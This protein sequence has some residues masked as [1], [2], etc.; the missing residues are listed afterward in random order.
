MM[1]L[2]IHYARLRRRWL[3]ITLLLTA[4]SFLL[5]FGVAQAASAHLAWDYTQAPGNPATG[6]YVEVCDGPG[7]TDF[8]RR[9]QTPLPVTQLT[10]TDTRGLVDG[11]TYSYRVRAVNGAGQRS[12]PSN[13]VQVE[14]PVR[15]SAPV[16][17][18]EPQP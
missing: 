16:L 9:M 17:R 1:L 2:T 18:L 10:Y 5:G 15:P 11:A 12:A 3:W 7:C 14:I 8:R 4:L 13:V 6:F